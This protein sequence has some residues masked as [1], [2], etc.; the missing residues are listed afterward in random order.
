MKFMPF[1]SDVISSS[2]FSNI[3]QQLFFVDLT[4]KI[5]F[6]HKFFEYFNY[7][8]PYSLYKNKVFIIFLLVIKFKIQCT[9]LF[10]VKLYKLYL[11]INK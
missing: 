8:V 5:F 11:Q 10:P 7:N 2:M 4:A 1:C 3:K 6:F 9:C